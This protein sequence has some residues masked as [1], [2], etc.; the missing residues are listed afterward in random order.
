MYLAP[1]LTCFIPNRNCLLFYYY[2]YYC[3]MKKTED[4]INERLLHS[5]Q[6]SVF[7]L[8]CSVLIIINE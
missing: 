4:K 6:K 1:F 2:Y 5:C 3:K 7:C 8:F